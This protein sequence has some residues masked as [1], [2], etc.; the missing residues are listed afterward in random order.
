MK[1]GTVSS[2][3]P[4]FI[5]FHLYGNKINKGIDGKGF[6]LAAKGLDSRCDNLN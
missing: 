4:L 2:H 1:Y 5:L 6:I 3:H